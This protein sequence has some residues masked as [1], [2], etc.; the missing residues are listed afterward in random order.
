M[1]KYGWQLNWQFSPLHKTPE[2]ILRIWGRQYK[3]EM[4]I[5]KTAAKNYKMAQAN[6]SALF[7]K[8]DLLAAFGC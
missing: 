8:G 1:D 5:I 6:N 7:P 4:R 2:N 3:I